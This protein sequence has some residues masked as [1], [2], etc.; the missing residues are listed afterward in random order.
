VK[1]DFATKSKK[2]GHATRFKDDKPDNTML[3]TMVL[4]IGLGIGLTLAAIYY[5]N[6]SAEPESTPVDAEK[7]PEKPSAKTRYKAVP[8]D[9]IE[10]PGFSFHDELENKTIEVEP[11]LLPETTETTD[12]TWVMQCGAF[13][14]PEMAENLRAKIGLSG[15]E[16]RI[17]SRQGKDGR[18]WHTVVLGPYKSKRLAGQH[19]RLLQGNAINDC[20]IW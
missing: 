15:L 20:K 7:V 3:I 13:R 16:A 14:K 18:Q 11:G 12:R 10:E 5:Y 9:E 6:Q 1:K 19:R 4:G 2:R 8:A 17:I